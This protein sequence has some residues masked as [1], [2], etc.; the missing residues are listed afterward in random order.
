MDEEADVYFEIPTW[1]LS[2]AKNPQPLKGGNE[3]SSSVVS[4]ERCTLMLK[5]HAF[6]ECP[7]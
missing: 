7:K 2:T 1:I 6:M 3:T 4:D 5:D